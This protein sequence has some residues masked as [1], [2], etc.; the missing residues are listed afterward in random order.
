MWF[1]GI[2]RKLMEV[3]EAWRPWI[4]IKDF[5]GW[6]YIFMYFPCSC[7][8]V[9]RRASD[10]LRRARWCRKPLIWC[11]SLLSRVSMAC[12]TWMSSAVFCDRPLFETSLRHNT[13]FTLISITASCL[14]N[15]R[16]RERERSRARARHC[17]K[18]RR[19]HLAATTSCLS[20]LSY[21]HWRTWT[22]YARESAG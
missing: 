16:E 2:L 5:H 19:L 11:S 10:L 14:E 9:L 18:P 8:N 13:Q 3:A 21:Q 1:S 4:K 17:N 7:F 12:E 22:S 20:L 6:P 15:A